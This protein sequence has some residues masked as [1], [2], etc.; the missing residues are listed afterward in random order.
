LLLLREVPAVDTADVGELFLSM[1][2]TL[3]GFTVAE[4]GDLSWTASHDPTSPSIGG[5][6]ERWVRISLKR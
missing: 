2:V 3:D 1:M 4:D 6:A 5:P